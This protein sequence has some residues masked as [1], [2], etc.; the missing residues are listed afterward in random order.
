MAKDINRQ[1]TKIYR[2]QIGTWKDVPHLMSSGKCIFKQW[3]TTTYLVEWPKS[4]HWQQPNTGG[5][6]E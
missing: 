5:N 4:S 1:L 2:W 6:V 3:C